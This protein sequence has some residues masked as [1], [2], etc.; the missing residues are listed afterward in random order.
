M[1]KMTSK[2]FM[3]ATPSLAPI[4]LFT[5]NRLESTRRTVEALLR[6]DLAARSEL[7]VYAD[8]PRR[9]QDAAQV[10]ELRRYLGTIDGFAKVTV[11]ERETNLGLSRNIV[12]G[13]TAVLD[14]FGK[15]IV[16]EDDLL[17]SSNFLRYMNEALDK[18]ASNPDVYSITGYSFTDDAP[19]VDSTYFLSLTSSWGWATWADRWKVFRKDPAAL[20][21]KL[22]DSRFKRRFDYND[23]YDFSGLVALDARGEVDSWAVYWY[24]SVLERGGLTLFPAKRLVQNI[25]YDGS[26][27]HCGN[28]GNEKPPPPYTYGLADD[29]AEGRCNRLAVERALFARRP[30]RLV[31]T[32]RRGKRK[33]DMALSPRAK[34]RVAQVKNRL[35]SLAADKSVGRHTFIDPTVH[36][37]GWRAIRVGHHT[38]IGGG[39]WLNVNNRALDEK[40]I[41]I[42]NNC[43]VGFRNFFTSG[44]LIELGDYVMTGVDCKFLGSDHVMKDPYA[45]YITTGTTHDSVMRIGDNVWLGAGVAVLGSVDIGRGSVIGAGALVTKSIPPFSVA[46][47]N[48]ARVVRRFDFARGAW[49]PAAEVTPE[50][51]ARM[52]SEEAYRERLTRDWPELSIPLQAASRSFGDIF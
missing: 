50:I 2:N 41:V 27:T 32:F 42:G 47:G 43:Y 49:I 11:V 51:E 29:V 36:V 26:G 33:L 25:G 3:P 39:S 16:L 22:K 6:N 46:I 1:D 8:G 13:V 20:A 18:Y 12:D 14:R 4:T 45:P 44:R 23:T 28:S 15:I 30:H 17:A 35:R 37:T 40:Q 48:P 31:D 5:Y 21:E 34:G 38:M 9:P 19:E 7:V 10:D 24:A 52:P